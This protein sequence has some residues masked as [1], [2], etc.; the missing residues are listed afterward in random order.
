MHRVLDAV[1]NNKTY[2]YKKYNCV[3]CAKNYS[4]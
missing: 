3:N 4:N 1:D 2:F